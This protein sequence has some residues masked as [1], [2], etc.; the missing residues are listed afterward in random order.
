M[1]KKLLMLVLGVTLLAELLLGLSSFLFA[2]DQLEDEAT[3]HMEDLG[4]LLLGQLS[5]EDPQ[6]QVLGWTQEFNRKHSVYRITVIDK[7]GTVLADSEEDPRGMGNHLMRKEVEQALATGFGSA[8]RQSATLP[9]QFLYV[10]VSDGEMVMRMS[11]TFDQIR[12]LQ[13]AFLIAMLA[14]GTATSLLAFGLSAWSVR[15]VLRPI[16][17]L[18]EGAARIAGG[19]LTSRIP[20]QPDEM[21][22]LAGEFNQMAAALSDAIHHERNQHAQLQAVMEAIPAGVIAIGLSGETLAC[23]PEARRLLDLDDELLGGSIYTFMR[24]PE[25]R[26]LLDAALV[27]SRRESMEWNG[28]KVL[29]LGCAPIVEEGETTGAVL[30]VSDMTHVRKLEQLRSEFVASATHELKTPL[31]A[32]R[33]CIEMLRD[34]MVGTSNPRVVSEMLEIMDVQ[35]ERLQA[36]ISDMLVLSEME[37]MAPCKDSGDLA[38][39][40]AEAAGALALLAQNGGVTLHIDVPGSL[41]A[42]APEDRLRRIAQNLIEN[43]IRY[44]K[45]GGS[46]W[47]RVWKQGARALV[48]VRDNGVGIPEKDQPR[49]FERFFRVDKDRSRNTGGTGLGLAIVK[50]TVRRYEGDL[51]LMS[52]EG[53]GSTFTVAIPA[54]EE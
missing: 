25:L 32:I 1:R 54:Q 46:V 4:I 22:V 42:R 34:P 41:I 28:G 26:K 6:A 45:Q 8:I 19:E 17:A 33:G 37:S 14:V 39:A 5:K 36:L 50:H 20:P 38:R 10:A 16:S 27:H 11:Q 48:S 15:H 30:V 51:E 40:V 49:V 18:R 9:E 35:G 23:N 52:S 13:N 21:G 29:R 7:S 31:T 3:A 47:V 44:N 12:R 24:A 43:A 53:E 2:R